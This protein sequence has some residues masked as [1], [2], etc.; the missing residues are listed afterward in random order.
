MNRMNGI[1]YKV[2]MPLTLWRVN[3]VH[4]LAP[5]RYHTHGRRR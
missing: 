1:D 3:P 5:I 2:F 4:G